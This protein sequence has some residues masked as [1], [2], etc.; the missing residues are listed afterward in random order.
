VSATPRW[1][2]ARSLSSVEVRCR[3]VGSIIEALYLATGVLDSVVANGFMIPRVVIEAR[4]GAVAL[5]FTCCINCVGYVEYSAGIKLLSFDGYPNKIYIL[6]DSKPLSE[7]IRIEAKS[8]VLAIG[9]ISV[10]YDPDEIPN[11]R[12]PTLS[13]ALELFT[14]PPAIDQ[15]YRD[16]IGRQLVE[17]WNNMRIRELVAKYYKASGTKTYKY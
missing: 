8:R 16:S 14:S 15:L 13:E 4:D 1:D 11:V 3:H 10:R 2:A 7:S 17:D 12:F 9:S 6:L 5:W